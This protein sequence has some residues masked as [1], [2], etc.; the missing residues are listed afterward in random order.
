LEHDP[1]KPYYNAF[2]IVFQLGQVG[3]KKEEN[4]SLFH[5]N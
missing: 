2:E 3:G 5:F 1:K 4:C